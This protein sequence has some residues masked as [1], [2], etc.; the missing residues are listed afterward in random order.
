MAPIIGRA[1][2]SGQAGWGL[3][4]TIWGPDGTPRETSGG[5][6]RDDWPR[7]AVERRG[8][9]RAPLGQPCLASGRAHREVR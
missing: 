7:G 1:Q 3:S 4:R 9:G 5:V 8:R 6:V 2:D